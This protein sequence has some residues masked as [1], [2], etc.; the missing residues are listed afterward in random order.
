MRVIQQL[1]QSEIISHWRSITIMTS[2][3]TVLLTNHSIKHINKKIHDILIP[4]TQQ[5]SKKIEQFNSVKKQTV[6][7]DIDSTNDVLI[8]DDIERNG[9]DPILDLSAGVEYEDK[10]KKISNKFM[11]DSTIGTSFDGNN[12]TENTNNTTN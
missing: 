1:A 12:K 9:K 7:K 5:P 4:N 11:P 6:A 3:S 8:A 2:F 10:S